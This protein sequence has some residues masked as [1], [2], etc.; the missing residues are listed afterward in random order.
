[1]REQGY[2]CTYVPSV[3]VRHAVGRSTR[4]E[5]VRAVKAFHESAYRLYWKHS[6]PIGR[7]FAPLVWMGLHGRETFLVR[8]VESANGKRVSTTAPPLDLGVGFSDSSSTHPSV[9]Q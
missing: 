5:P 3:S 6:G 8:R 2:A 1:V 9:N 4:H 7:L